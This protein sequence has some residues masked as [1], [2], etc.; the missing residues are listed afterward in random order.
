M[1]PNG[2]MFPL[3]R[4]ESNSLYRR[5]AELGARW[6]APECKPFRC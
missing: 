1:I 6:I 3:S 5:L 4:D 2:I